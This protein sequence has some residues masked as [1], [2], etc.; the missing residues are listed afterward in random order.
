MLFFF[1]IFVLF[2]IFDLN[3]LLY[4]IFVVLLLYYLM[5]VGLF[6]YWLEGWDCICC[7]VEVF[8]VIE[9]EFFCD[10]YGILVMVI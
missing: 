9:E 7:C 4:L 10:V 3:V 5:V 1:L 6:I 2:L 8:V